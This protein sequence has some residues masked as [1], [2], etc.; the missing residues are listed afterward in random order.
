MQKLFVLIIATL[1][2]VAHSSCLSSLQP[3]ATAKTITT[4]NRLPG[5]WTDG[6]ESFRIQKVPESDL[7]RDSENPD[8]KITLSFSD[9]QSDSI[10]FSN[11]YV[12]STTRKD[13]AEYLMT[14]IL[15]RIN[16]QYFV[17]F[18]SLGIKHPKL[19]DN[20]SGFEFNTDYLPTFSVAQ[21]SFA[22]KD[23]IV[24]KFLNGDFIKEQLNKGNLRLK[25]EK[26]ALF[27]SFLITASSYELQQ[28]LEKYGHDE[29]LYYGDDKNA[30]LTRK[31]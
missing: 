22:S 16:D 27:G 19:G 29:R 4:D 2:M 15:S 12:I 24:L 13:G 1:L 5:E 7:L 3:V 26:D 31:G 14:G 9:N 11:S 23:K 17:D 28:F 30:E 10:F 8:K 6:K 20:G 25:Y 21:L 18:M